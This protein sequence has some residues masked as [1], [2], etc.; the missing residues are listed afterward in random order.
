M[1]D[2][3]ASV[4]SPSAAVLGGEALLRAQPRSARDWIPLARSGLPALAIDAM[5]RQTRIAQT[6]L[7]KAL[8]IPERT[9]ARRKREGV[10]SPDES[11]KLIRLVRLVERAAEVF[12]SQDRA[13]DWIKT[14]NA[15]LDGFTPLSMLDTELGAETVLDMLGRIEH[16][17][18]A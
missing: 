5:V 11:A 16:G 4:P 7:A 18:F 15:S 17:I 6:E 10:F 2:L 3:T 13:V 8:A 9:L 12:E 14:P 1:A